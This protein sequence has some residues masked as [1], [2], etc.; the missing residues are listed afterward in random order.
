MCSHFIRAFFSKDFTAFHEIGD[1]L[2]LVLHPE[3]RTTGLREGFP[4]GLVLNEPF[5]VQ[6]TKE[7]IYS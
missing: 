7:E 3:L 4:C 5:L 1:S 2:N 6:S